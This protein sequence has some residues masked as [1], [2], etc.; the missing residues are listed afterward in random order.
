MK[1]R[2][3]FDEFDSGQPVIRLNHL[4]VDMVLTLEEVA[5]IERAAKIVRD[6]AAF[7]RGQE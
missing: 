3:E 7:N 1:I 4:D 5:M 6:I 2:I